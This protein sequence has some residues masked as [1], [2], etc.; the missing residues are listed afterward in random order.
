MIEKQVITTWY[1]PEEELPVDDGQYIVTFSGKDSNAD[2]DHVLGI[3]GWYDD[4]PGWDIEGLTDN[5]EFLI[6]AWCD[7]DPYRA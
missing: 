4:G 5:A 3:A 7:L 2:Y 6:H 1:T